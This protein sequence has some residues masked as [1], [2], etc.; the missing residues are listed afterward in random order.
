M[1]TIATGIQKAGSPVRGV[2][3][4]RATG[5]GVVNKSRE[6]VAAIHWLAPCKLRRAKDLR[7]KPAPHLFGVR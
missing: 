7:N 4:R 3:C 1:P 6:M 2:L 5:S